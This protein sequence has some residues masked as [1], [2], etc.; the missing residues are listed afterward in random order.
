MS[1]KYR[2][3]LLEMGWSLLIALLF[4]FINGYY[5][6]NGDQEEHLP[7]VYKLLNPALYPHDYLVPLQTTTFTV[8][9]YFAWMLYGLGQL[10]PIPLSVFIL[11]IFCISFTAYFIGKITVRA[12][13]VKESFLLAPVLALLLLNRFTVGGNNLMDV[14]LTC[15][16]FAL[17]S[18]LAAFYSVMEGKN[19]Q[20][21]IL[22][23]IASLFQILMGIHLM[24]LISV[25]I[26]I[27]S[28]R[29]KVSNLLRFLFFYCVISAFVIIPVFRHQF[30]LDSTY[31]Q[32]LFYKILYVFR[33][34]NH[35]L[36]DD[37]PVID[38]L[39]TI[40]WWAIIL[41]SLSVPII[42]SFTNSFKGVLITVVTGCIIYILIL[43]F[44]NF[45]WVGKLQ[46]F[47]TTVWVTLLGV[48]PVCNM[49]FNFGGV[50]LFF[51]KYYNFLMKLVFPVC[52]I[53][54]I[55][56]TN[57]SY[58]PVDRLQHR[59]QIGN[60]KLSDLDKMHRWIADSIPVDAVILPLPDDDGFMCSAKRS[61]PIGFK[62]IIHEPYFLVPWYDQI[63]KIYGVG[64][65]DKVGGQ[66]VILKAIEKYGSRPDS[67]I[68]SKIPIDFRM[69]DTSNSNAEI[70][71]NKT[72]IHREGKYILSR[73]QR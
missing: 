69:W 32:V 8:R 55:A 52:F 45:T 57:C 68:I 47:K 11:H 4:I 9:F 70:L 39:K 66:E 14:E 17:V 72:V 26:F 30:M 62:A 43:N 36:P 34:P 13:Q 7:Y 37:F 63:I 73:F 38:Y 27:Y 2:T 65:D 19:K 50:R 22:V 18:G 25:F 12:T 49:I 10:F 42:K 71:K 40:I 16:S 5:F 54:L 58:L 6:N 3:V 56:I 33:N 1:N 15:S 59:Y 51:K 61:I 64:L 35:Y 53:L 41:F 24:I 67:V 23:G 20:A 29:Y 44:N 31:N 46:W 60:Y 48:V 21:G 28:S